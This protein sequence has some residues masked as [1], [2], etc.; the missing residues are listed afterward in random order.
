M[1]G[2]F[3]KMAFIQIL[4]IGQRLLT[5]WLGKREVESSSALTMAIWRRVSSQ[6]PVRIL[7]ND[8]HYVHEHGR[9]FG[10]NSWR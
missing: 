10:I 8:S 3:R 9:F 4:N 7:D 1:N 6:F 5:R 2:H